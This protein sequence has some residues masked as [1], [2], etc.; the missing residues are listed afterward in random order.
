MQQG[1]GAVGVSPVVQ[2]LLGNNGRSQ[3]GVA[4]G[5][6]VI[7]PQDTTITADKHV[8]QYRAN[9]PAGTPNDQVNKVVEKL[10]QKVNTS[11]T[12]KDG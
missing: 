2:N 4:V 6:Q 1:T 8:T 12:T 5:G 10:Q 3:A 7:Q 11:G 9:I